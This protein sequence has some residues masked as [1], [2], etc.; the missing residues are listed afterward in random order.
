MCGHGLV[1][2]CTFCSSIFV[3]R[4]FSVLLVYKEFYN[5]YLWCTFTICN[6]NMFLFR[7]SFLRSPVLHFVPYCLLV[8]FFF[9]SIQSITFFQWFEDGIQHRDVYVYVYSVYL[10]RTRLTLL[11]FFCKFRVVN[12]IFIIGFMMHANK[13]SGNIFLLNIKM[14]CLM[15]CAS[16]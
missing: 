5:T 7:E 10:K 6:M 15:G 9:W 4:D 11:L 2:A 3:F 8:L 12:K 1:N 13:P 16:E 14:M